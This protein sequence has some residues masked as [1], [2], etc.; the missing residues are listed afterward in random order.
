MKG[1]SPL[2]PILFIISSSVVSESESE[3]ESE[4]N[5]ISPVLILV[6][7]STSS[8]LKSGLFFL[9]IFLDIYYSIENNNSLNN[10]I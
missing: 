8:N 2:I 9:T 6:S 1:V 3:S 10:L 5:L 4:A 7:E